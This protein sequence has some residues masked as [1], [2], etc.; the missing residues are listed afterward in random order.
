V[1]E[2]TGAYGVH[3]LI[4]SFDA[5]N[6]NDVFQSL[7]LAD[8]VSLAANEIN[9][10]MDGLY[11][12]LNSYVDGAPTE[13]F[14]SSPW[15]WWDVAMTQMV[16]T[17]NGSN[18]AATQLSLNP[19]M[20]PEEALPWMDIIQAYTAPRMYHALGF[21]EV[22]SVEEAIANDASF[23]IFP[24]PTS[25]LT[26]IDLKTPAIQASLFSLDGRLVRQWPLVGI[27]GQFSVDLSDVSNGTYIVQIDGESQRISVT[28]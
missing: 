16:D 14:D 15:Q 22:E 6:N 11:P 2:V 24:N 21:G 23:A 13:P 25:G 9:E 12:V 28:R 27:Q 26:T 7:N 3:T 19:T 17:A 4:N 10:G 8:D 20:G 5:P 18:I 1:I